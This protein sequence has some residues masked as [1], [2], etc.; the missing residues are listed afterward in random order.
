MKELYEKRK[1]PTPA[2]W[3]EVLAK[4]D[5][6][7]NT[8]LSKEMQVWTMKQC[9]KIFEESLLTLRDRYK[10]ILS[11]FQMIND[12]LMGIVAVLN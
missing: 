9:L 10:V 4:E 6:E 3:D 12:L 2:K 11:F 7:P 8:K 5:E 1:P